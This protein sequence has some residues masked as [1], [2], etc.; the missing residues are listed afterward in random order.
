MFMARPVAAPMTI[1]F[2]DQGYHRPKDRPNYGGR[3]AAYAAMDTMSA[4]LNFATGSFI[5]P[6]A[7]PARAPCWMS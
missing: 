1:A 5:N 7:A 4:R 3:V 6:A 2:D